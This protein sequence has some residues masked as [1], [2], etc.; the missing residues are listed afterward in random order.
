MAYGDA[1]LKRGDNGPEV[2]ELQM[3]LSGFRG[4]VPDGD[5]GPG[6]ELQ[7]TCFQRDWMK[8]AQPSGSADSATLAAIADF[9]AK[10]PVDFGVLRCRCGACHGFGAGKSRDVYHG[11]RIE[12]NYDYEYPGI[13][14][15]LLWSYR[16]A[17]YYAEPKGW[18]LT[19]NSGYRCSEDNKQNHR[20]S[21]N[22][23]GKAIDID[24]LDPP[25]K[26]VDMARCNELRGILVERA[27]AQ[28]GWGAANRKSLEPSDIAPTWVHL[29]VRNYDR[30]HLD[31]RYFVSDAAQLDRAP[32]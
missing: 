20:T 24:I 14:R 11:P 1:P 4:T 18:K 25:S 2:V 9:G 26:P 27:N 29:D 22:H 6:T 3:R 21:T 13:H 5:Y 28:I 15:M 17:M 10:H 30:R 8:M 19:I 12:A 23:H 7:V 16:A 32:A 31:D